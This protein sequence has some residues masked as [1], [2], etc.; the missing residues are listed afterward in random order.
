MESQRN[1]KPIHNSPTVFVDKNISC[2]RSRS[3]I[4][5]LGADKRAMGC[6]S[7]RWMRRCARPVANVRA[8]RCETHG[9]ARKP[10]RHAA[11]AGTAVVKLQSALELIGGGLGRPARGG[12][13]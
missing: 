2:F 3:R 4:N 8:M 5:S 7:T 13:N 10:C 9:R 11:I 1:H 12:S 6:E